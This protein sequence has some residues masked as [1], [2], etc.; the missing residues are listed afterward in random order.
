MNWTSGLKLIF[1]DQKVNNCFITTL[2]IFYVYP[3]SV[4]YQKMVNSEK[5]LFFFKYHYFII[6][7]TKK[8]KN[9]IF[10]KK[11]HILRPTV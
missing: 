4:L 7:N 1:T 2:H 6:Y 9:Q 10:K 11:V 8:V 5:N 3:R